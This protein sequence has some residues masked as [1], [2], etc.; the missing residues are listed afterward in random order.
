MTVATWAGGGGCDRSLAMRLVHTF[1]RGRRVGY[2]PGMA[3]GP[4]PPD[5]NLVI[6]AGRPTAR[7]RLD[8]LG[9]VRFRQPPDRR[10]LIRAWFGARLQ[11]RAS[12]F[13]DEL[14]AACA[15]SPQISVHEARALPARARASARTAVAEVL[16][17]DVPYRRLYGSCVSPDERLLLAAHDWY[18]QDALE[19]EAMAKRFAQ[20]NLVGNAIASILTPAIPP[21]L[22]ALAGV[23]RQMD[24]VLKIFETSIARHL[25]VATQIG[26]QFHAQVAKL[27]AQLAPLHTLVADLAARIRVPDVVGSGLRKLGASPWPAL[28]AGLKAYADYLERRWPDQFVEN[29]QHPPPVLFLLASMPSWVG[30]PLLRTMRRRLD[31]RFVDGLEAAIERSACLSLARQVLVL[32][33]TPL[34]DIGRR[35]LLVGLSA[36]AEGRYVDATP[37]LY[38]G[39]EAAFRA[40][41][42]RRGIIDSR[43]CYVD[44]PPSRRAR[45]EQI[46]DLFPHLG[47]DPKFTRFLRA[48]VFGEPGGAIRHGDSLDA[49]DHR[50]W[51]LLAGI[52]TLGWLEAFAVAPEPL[53]AMNRQLERE[54]MPLIPARLQSPA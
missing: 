20:L 33:A 4:T 31:E 5:H 28:W 12:L 36:L 2:A 26:R 16:G 37:P 52:A 1:V 39:L 34:P 32:E 48:W 24:R 13:V 29:P 27:T 15:E 45:P 6:R 51:A 25:D 23:G 21:A 22:N 53:D 8:R 11:P 47:L 49:A 7:R 9:D 19:R 17:I 42:R 43:G 54:V 18:R 50:R 44:R 40:S 46:E 38:Q 3:D 35:H 14:I 10:A 41:A 30:I